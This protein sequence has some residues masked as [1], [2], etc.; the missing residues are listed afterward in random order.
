MSGQPKASINIASVINTKNTRTIK[1]V[2]PP[3]EISMEITTAVIS[4][5]RQE[6]IALVEDI[7]LALGECIS[8]EAAS[9]THSPL[10]DILRDKAADLIANAFDALAT[11]LTI[12]LETPEETDFDLTQLTQITFVD[13]G[14]GFLDKE[15]NK[16]FADHMMTS[17]GNYQKT[18]I[19]KIFSLDPKATAGASLSTKTLQ[20]QTVGGMG[21]ALSHIYAIAS[22]PAF[23]GSLL[24]GNNSPHG[25]IV[26]II[27]PEGTR[28][29]MFHFNEVAKEAVATQDFINTQ[30]KD[31]QQLKETPSIDQREAI[32]TTKYSVQPFVEKVQEESEDSS[33]DEEISRI[34]SLKRFSLGSLPTR[35]HYFSSPSP[36]SA[37]SASSSFGTVSSTLF[38]QRSL[39]SM[40]AQS[41]ETS[42]PDASHGVSTLFTAACVVTPKAVKPTS[43]KPMA[44]QQLSLDE[45]TYE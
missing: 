24:L 2:F 38:F 42:I 3:Q 10:L 17:Y 33:S 31:I 20:T 8:P 21:L 25:A 39:S 4:K 18:A 41:F 22:H 27:V 15:D 6:K 35:N 11:E 23:N 7:R 37:H 43:R 45:T 16:R 19:E 30:L 5:V 13:N 9:L 34:S 12:F 44:L 36:G 32:L 14:L 40:S 1:I 29:N 28:T 26:E